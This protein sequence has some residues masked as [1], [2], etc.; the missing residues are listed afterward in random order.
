MLTRSK[1]SSGDE[2]PT[3]PE[4][5]RISFEQLEKEMGTVDYYD[6]REDE[7]LESFSSVSSGTESGTDYDSVNTVDMSE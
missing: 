5:K 3:N 6:E 1:T 2:K 7:D 4:F